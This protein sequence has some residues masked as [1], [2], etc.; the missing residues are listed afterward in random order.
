MK[1]TER[2]IKLPQIDP[3]K[4]RRE[5]GDGVIEKVLEFN[6]TGCVIGLS[7]GA[8]ST[9]SAA[10]IKQAFDRYNANNPETPLELVGYILPS[11]TNTP[12]DTRDGIMVAQR[13]GIRYE[14]I[15]LE[16]VVEAHRTTNPEAFS[17]DYDKGNM[18]SRIRGNVLNTKG[19]SENKKVA[20]TGNRDEDD[21]IGYYTMFGDGAVHFSTLGN[22]SKRLVFQMLRYHGF[23]EIAEREP[24][25]GLEPHQTDFGDLGYYY[26]VVEMVREGLRQR[27]TQ[28]ELAQHSQ[29]V[30]I[31]QRDLKQY[32]DMF[33]VSKFD[34]VKEVVNDIVR[35]NIIA[36]KKASLIHPPVIPVTLEYV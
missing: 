27:F 20:G 22:L 11:D 9:M 7:G 12:E 4:A 35:R 16:T 5:I 3:E 36:K 2:R 26:D 29:V 28:E 23:T 1:M 25:A 6:A 32:S 18:M 19:D 10:E 30:G 33:G 8:D 15:S 34:S 31:A 13:L 14:V 24:S 17:S 21:G